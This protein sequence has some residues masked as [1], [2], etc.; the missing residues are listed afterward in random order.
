MSTIRPTLPP[1]SGYVE[2]EVDGIRTYR[3][4]KTGLLIN[5]ETFEMTTEGRIS[6]LQT[7]LAETDE[8]AIALYEAWVAQEAVSTEQ[9]EAILELYELLGGKQ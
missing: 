2:V 1:K 5:E 9:D 7:A 3:N 4:V 8:I 6:S